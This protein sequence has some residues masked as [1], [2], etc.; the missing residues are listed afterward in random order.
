VC[1]LNPTVMLK[2]SAAAKS[3]EDFAILGSIR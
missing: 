3:A 1:G 2:G